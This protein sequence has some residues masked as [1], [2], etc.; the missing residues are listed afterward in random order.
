MV[1]NLPGR[2]PLF[3]TA[4]FGTLE[5]R[6]RGQSVIMGEAQ[7]KERFGKLQYVGEIEYGE[8][9]LPQLRLGLST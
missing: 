5:I 9:E 4:A 8:A 6:G 7:T 2:L 1:L 3:R